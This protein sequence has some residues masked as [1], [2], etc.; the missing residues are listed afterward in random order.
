MS[1]DVLLGFG[2]VLVAGI[3]NGSFAVPMKK[4]TAWAWENIWLAWTAMALVI[5]PLA[6]TLA[7][8]PRTGEFYAAASPRILAAV[9]ACGLAWGVAQVLFGLGLSRAGVALGFALVVG[10]AAAAGSLVPL[11]LLRSGSGTQS[12]GPGVVA[13][14]AVVLAGVAVCAYAGDKRDAV[15]NPQG[16]GASWTG[17]LMCVVAGVAGSAINLGM[18]IGAPLLAQA[19]RHGVPK[20][21]Q[22]N[23]IWLPVLLA[24]FTPTA[25]Y[26]WRRLSVNS[27]WNRFFAPGVRWYWLLA[28]LMAV[29]YFGS[30]ELY[31]I[32]AAKMGAWGPVLGW[33]AFLSA[34]IITANIWGLAT[35][36]WRHAGARPRRLMLAGV[37]VLIA[38]IFVIGLAGR[39]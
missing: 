35:G 1:L 10:V 32:A 4:T 5:F 17:I 14:V 3:M 27:T 21:H 36:E 22:V 33:P 23:V 34:S 12:P 15:T 18:V 16:G 13:G 30:V 25:I 11:V 39:S 19:E 31:G 2:M 26:C 6:L 8:T 7:T 20:L 9:L 29:C 28:A 38:A 37:S 24:G